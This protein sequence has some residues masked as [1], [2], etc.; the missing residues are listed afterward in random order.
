M[1]VCGD[2]QF[3]PSIY[4]PPGA[5]SILGVCVRPVATG[6]RRDVTS[7]A[8]LAVMIISMS[9]SEILVDAPLS[10]ACPRKSGFSSTAHRMKYQNCTN[11][12]VANGYIAVN[13][14]IYL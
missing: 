11:C 5:W 2:I 14:D 8:D 3:V 10:C 13:I 12:R 4:P 1:L 7:F 9:K 6:I